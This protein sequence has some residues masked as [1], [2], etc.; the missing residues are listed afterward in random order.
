M[1]AYEPLPSTV[2]ARLIAALNDPDLGG[3]WIASAPLAEACGQD[4]NAVQAS[5]KAAVAHGLVETKRSNDGLHYWRKGDG[6][7]LPKQSEPPLKHEVESEVPKSAW[8]FAT[9]ADRVM[10]DLAEVTHRPIVEVLDPSPQVDLER[11]LEPILDSAD[12]VLAIR[13]L[14]DAVAVDEP[15]PTRF[16]LW[17]DG[18]LQLEKSGNNTV[19]SVEET[20]ALLG[21]LERMAVTG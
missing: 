13:G 8:P 15:A 17:S 20:R 7:P 2:A 14:I 9:N 10:A 11:T 19:L 16:A 5:L 18:R 6:V 1:G 4:K 3:D 21:Y 12:E